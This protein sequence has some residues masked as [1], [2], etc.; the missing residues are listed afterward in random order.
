MNPFIKSSGIRIINQS[1]KAGAFNA[2]YTWAVAKAR[3]K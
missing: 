2:R 3:A 1:F